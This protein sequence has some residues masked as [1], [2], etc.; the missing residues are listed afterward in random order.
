MNWVLRRSMALVS[1]VMMLAGCGRRSE[2]VSLIILQTGGLYGN[3]YPV[4]LNYAAPRQ[5]YQYISAYV[6]SV[7]EEAAKTG[8]EVVLFDSGNSLNGSFAS[9][10]LDSENV[11]TFFNKVGY[12]AII[13]GNQDIV[14]PMKSLS[15]VREPMLNPFRAA[16]SDHRPAVRS[17]SIVLK[18]GRLEIRLF[19]VFCPDQSSGWPLTPAG[20]PGGFEPGV[21]PIVNQTGHT[22]H[23]LNVC[24]ALNG[25]CFP[26][27]D[28]G[29]IL[30]QTG[31]DVWSGQAA[32]GE[33]NLPP[34]PSHPDL[35]LSQSFCSK[36]GEDYVAR[37][38][39][40]QTHKGWRTDRRQLVRVDGEVVHADKVV[41]EELLPLSQRLARSNRLVVTLN[42]RID[43]GAIRELVAKALE[44]IEPGAGWI[45]PK[46][47]ESATWEAGPL[48]LSEIFDL[49][50]WDD[51]VVLLTG[52]Q[53]DFTE[54]A[55]YYWIR[56]MGEK[57]TIITLRS[58]ADRLSRDRNFSRGGVYI[59]GTGQKVYETVAARLSE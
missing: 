57:S 32:G 7:R 27:P 10:I 15:K 16:D 2:S 12:D 18:K 43:Q 13:L 40:H 4:S 24:V 23:V 19:A 8:A 49:F 31:A 6:R 30:G 25:N 39:L 17:D 54:L 1:G 55:K 46:P 29:T 11:A 20:I 41:V 26:W 5:S 37:I 33:A 58:I 44:K 47:D 34:N 48:H 50:P 3:V 52:L 35:V 38:D 22:N 28:L 21:L 51:E 53:P 14:L 45:L 42:Q 9:Q 59:K 56:P 36:R